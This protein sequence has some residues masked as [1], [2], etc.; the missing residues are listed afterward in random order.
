LIE[1]TL[2]P[3]ARSKTPMDDAVTPLPRPETTPGKIGLER[4]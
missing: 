3:P 4:V 2:H 1:V